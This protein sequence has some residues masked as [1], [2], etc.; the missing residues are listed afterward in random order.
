LLPKPTEF[1]ATNR[2]YPDVAAF[3]HNIAAY[4]SGLVQVRFPHP[5]RHCFGAFTDISCCTPQLDGTSAATPI[6]AAYMAAAN[7][8]RLARGKP[9]LGFVNPAIYDIAAHG[10]RGVHRHHYRRQHVHRGVQGRLLG[11][12]RN[13]RLGRRDWLELPRRTSVAFCPR[14]PLH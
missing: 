10:I 14:G 9:T 2:G 11:L 7:A 5:D 1:N 3:A 8:Q 6:F 4:D 12:W 13:E